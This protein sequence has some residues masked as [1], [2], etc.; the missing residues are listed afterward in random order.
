MAW[1]LKAAC[2]RT[3]LSQ[4]LS[5]FACLNCALVSAASLIQK[6]QCQNLR[7]FLLLF[8]P[9]HTATFPYTSLFVNVSYLIL[10][11]SFF[12]LPELDFGPFWD[13]ETTTDPEEEVFQAT[14]GPGKRW[15]TLSWLHQENCPD[16]LGY[17]LHI[18]FFLAIRAKVIAYWFLYCCALSVTFRLNR[19]IER[20]KP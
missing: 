11:T 8:F 3:M 14:W 4:S 19:V 20:I 17:C 15:K 18:S 16:T 7:A 12:P 9:L 1:G 10:W 5:R 13:Q 2:V 6:P